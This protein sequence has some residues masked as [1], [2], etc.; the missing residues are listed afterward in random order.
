MKVCL[1]NDSFPPMLDGVANTVQNY[2]S[3]MK[4]DELADAVVVTPAYPDADYSIYP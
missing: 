3:V 1:L 4:T 2:A